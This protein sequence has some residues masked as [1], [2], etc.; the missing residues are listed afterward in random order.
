MSA[1]YVGRPESSRVLAEVGNEHIAPAEIA[2]WSVFF[3]RWMPGCDSTDAE[4]AVVRGFQGT[5]DSTTT[6]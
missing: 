6:A 5:S 1:R 2:Y 4:G 3:G